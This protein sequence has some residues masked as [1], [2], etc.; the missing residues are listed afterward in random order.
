[1]TSERM[2]SA[3]LSLYPDTFRREYGWQMAQIF[4]DC[5]RQV[6]REHRAVGGRRTSG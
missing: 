5:R 4:H 3:L 6:E 2:Y 1:M